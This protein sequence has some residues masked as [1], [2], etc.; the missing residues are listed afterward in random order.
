MRCTFLA[1][2]GLGLGAVVSVTAGA[3]VANFLTPSAPSPASIG[4]LMLFGSIGTLG[5][6][7]WEYA[8]CKFEY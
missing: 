7:L 8:K 3:T 5:G 1:L 6:W 4:V 2:R